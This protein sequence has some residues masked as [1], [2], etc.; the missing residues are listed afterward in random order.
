M[1]VDIGPKIGISGEREFR[2]QLGEVNQSLKTLGSEM[3]AVTSDTEKNAK[4]IKG[5]KQQNEVLAKTEDALKQKLDMQNKALQES[6]KKY[7][8]TD[9]KTLKWQ[10]A[11]NET[12]AALNKN[13]AAIKENSKSMREMVF[14]KVEAGAKAAAAGIAAIG[15]A[16]AA[17]VGAVVKLTTD[18]AKWADDLAT[19]SQQ[20]SISTDQLQK[21]QYAAG[22]INVETETI[23]GSLTKLAKNMYSAKDGTGATAEAF[24]QLGVE[25]TDANGNLR[26]NEDV[27][28]DVIDALGN[29]ESETERDAIAM[30]LM[31]KSAQQLNPLIKGGAKELER[32]G[33]EAEEA[34]LILDEDAVN[35]LSHVNDAMSLMQNSA[36]QLGRSFSV[37]FAEPISGA[38]ETVTG[39]IHQ[40]SS[41]F[42]EGGLGA[43][44][45]TIGAI[46]S[47]VSAKITEYLPQVMEFGLQI[48]MTLLQG[49]IAQAPQIIQTGILVIQTLLDGLSEQLPTL[50]PLAVEAILTIV[51]TLISNADLLIDSSIAIIVALADGLISSLPTLIEK[52]PQIVQKLV[53]AIVQNAPKLLTSALQIIVQLVQGLISNL[54][55]VV[56]AAGQIIS[57]L[58]SGIGNLMSQVWDIGKRIVEGIWQG[59]QNAASWFASQVKNF[60]SNIIKSVKSVLG[61]KSPSKV[62]AGI[63][64]NMALGL[65]V[66]FEDEIGD[67]E[68][69]I[70]SSVAGLVP[71]SSGGGIAIGTSYGGQSANFAN[72]IKAALNGCAVVMDGK[73]VGTLI[74]NMQNNTTRARGA[75][76]LL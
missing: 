63:G 69:D 25:I 8:E 11:V 35:K 71:T 55:K 49:L 75:A 61:I 23:T 72:A 41:S 28:A 13:E 73:K 5:L 66:G 51:D 47:D 60:F 68:R 21:Y 17:A 29:V 3:K 59:I 33:K 24:A 64:K 10:Q 14:D 15:A 52:A 9:E 39:Y 30:Q 27:F 50:I 70:N 32:L 16:A 26:D 37:Q 18:S 2:Q 54:P 44:G 67:V 42:S 7:G 34:G 22:A 56:S 53:D 19:L 40:L 65:G 58:V 12:T 57:S 31:G 45:E 36:K 38:I 20:T 74:T 4:G 46:L 1:A 43:M 76:V 48:V 62:F 6:I